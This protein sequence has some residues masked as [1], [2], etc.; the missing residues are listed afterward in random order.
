M[1]VLAKK[2]NDLRS[3]LDFMDTQPGQLVTNNKPVYS[4]AKWSV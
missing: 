3:G 1:P 4:E 2:I